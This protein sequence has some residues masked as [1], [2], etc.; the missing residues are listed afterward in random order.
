VLVI[1]GLRVAD[2]R[3]IP[4]D[5]N[6]MLGTGLFL[7]DAEISVKL[8]H[9]DRGPGVAIIRHDDDLRFDTRQIAGEDG[10]HFT[11]ASGFIAKLEADACPLDMIKRS[12]KV[13]A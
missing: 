2:L 12:I 11:H 7:K 5:D 9:D 10:V 4:A 3:C 6:P 1:E 8:C 13:E